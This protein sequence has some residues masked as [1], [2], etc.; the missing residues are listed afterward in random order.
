MVRDGK[1]RGTL[2]SV[3]TIGQDDGRQMEIVRGLN[4]H[5]DVVAS[6][7]GAIGEGVPVTV[8]KEETHRETKSAH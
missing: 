1:S 7:R 8:T 4:P 5:D 6:F 3:I 2:L